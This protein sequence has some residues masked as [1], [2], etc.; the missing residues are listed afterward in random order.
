MLEQ[1]DQA[2]ALGGHHAELVFDR[3]LRDA[4]PVEV[5]GRQIYQPVHVLHQD[6]ALPARVFI[7]GQL[8]E[9]AGEPDDIRAP[10]AVEVHHQ[11]GIAIGNLALDDMVAELD[12]AGRRKAGRQQ[13]P[14]G[15][16]HGP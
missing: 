12:G 16:S 13:K 1:P 11:Q 15:S 6:V 5:V 14:Y 2:L 9:A 4:V 10:I 8:A 3:Q 7:P